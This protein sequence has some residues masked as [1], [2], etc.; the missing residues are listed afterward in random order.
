LVPISESLE[1]D[2]LAMPGDRENCARHLTAGDLRL[3]SLADQSET[4]GRHADIFGL[5]SRE[6]VFGKC[7]RRAAENGN[8]SDGK[9]NVWDVHGDRLP[10]GRG[11][12]L[13]KTGPLR[14]R[15]CARLA[16][17]RVMVKL[18]PSPI[19]RARTSSPSLAD[20]RDDHQ[21]VSCGRGTNPN[22]DIAI[23]M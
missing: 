23:S 2:E 14:Y 21:L 20:I 17:A 6:R 11:Q 4:L 15:G 1:I 13:F 16:S 19:R 9:H 7:H 5:S 12:I 10:P 18:G 3:D 8:C 22:L